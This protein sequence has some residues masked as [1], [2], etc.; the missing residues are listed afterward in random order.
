MRIRRL[1]RRQIAIA[2][3]VSLIVA[4]CGS[5]ATPAP[6]SANSA[7][8]N[9][10]GGS[11]AGAGAG[12]VHKTVALV[13][14]LNIDLFQNEVKGAQAAADL[15]GIKLNVSFTSQYNEQNYISSIESA[16]ATK[17]DGIIFGMYTPGYEKVVDEA[18]AQGIKVVTVNGT[19]R[20]NATYNNAKYLN[21]GFA[22]PSE[23]DQSKSLAQ[24]FIGYLPQGG[25]EVLEINNSPGDPGHQIRMDTGKAIFE[26]AGYTVDELNGSMDTATAVANVASYISAHPHIIGAYTTGF[27]SAAAV[28]Q[29]AQQA[30]LKI[31]VS[32]FD[33]SADSI[34]G[35]KS[36]CIAVIVDQQFALEGF[37]SVMNLYHAFRW[38]T[39]PVIVNTGTFLVTKDNVDTVPSQF[40]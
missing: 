26:A 22:G 7:A 25:G 3:V 35:I 37:F 4:G 28:C 30:N 21:L 36:G 12:Q 1:A 6:S 31:P 27:N 5:S 18:L 24:A 2:M 34:A 40:P 9:P 29:Y 20:N 33:A 23:I 11:S 10:S 39:Q 14:P 8:A 38:G 32:S 15:V 16:I 13:V 17:P 19:Q